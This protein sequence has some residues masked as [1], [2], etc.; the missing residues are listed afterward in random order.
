MKAW[1]AL[2]ALLVAGCA[3]A[4][5]AAPVIDPVPEETT[6]EVSAEFHV[7][8]TLDTCGAAGYCIGVFGSNVYAFG[9]ATY[10][11]FRLTVAPSPETIDAG[12]PGA[13]VRITAK[14]T[15]ER[16]DHCPGLL[17]ETE[18]PWPATIEV[19]GFRIESPEQLTF[20]VDYVGPYPQPVNGSGAQY[21]LKGTLTVVDG[22]EASA[23]AMEE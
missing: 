13:Q 6:R 7:I 12:V 5:E 22:S 2:V 14:C 3:A 11:G 23:P 19:S 17:A 9:D 16:T 20:R 18:G 4:P 8:S 21:D 1:L 10:V 15:G